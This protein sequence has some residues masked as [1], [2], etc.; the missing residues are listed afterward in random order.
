MTG[1]PG[2][3]TIVATQESPTSLDFHF[4][5]SDISARQVVETG[6]FVQVDLGQDLVLG[7]I[8]SLRRS[9]RYF[10]SPDII[11]GSSQGNS[12]PSVYPSDRWDYLVAHVKVLGCFRDGLQI[13]STRPVLPGS[14]VHMVNETILRQFLGLKKQGL[15]LGKLRQSN[16]PAN[17]DLDR[18][19]KKHLAILSISGGGKSYATSV[20]I[21]ELLRRYPDQ[22]RPAMVM[23]DVHGEYSSLTQ[24][25]NDR[26]F[27]DVE[28]VHVPSD[29][30]AMSVRNLE[31]SDFA[32]FFPS[33]SYAQ[34]RELQAVLSQL[35]K[36]GNGL[37]IDHIISAIYEREMNQLVKDALLGWVS[38]LKHS[39]LFGNAEFPHIKKTLEPGKLIIL[40][41]SGYTSL[42]K[43]R[44]LVHYFLTRIFDLRRS[45]DI[46]PVIS[47]IEEAHQFAPEVESSTSK[48]IIH[49]I[50]REGRKFLCSLVLISQRPVNLSTTALSQCNSQLILRIL[51]P[52]DLNYIGK[53]SE[54]IN[55]ETLSMLTS[56]GVG[57]AL[58]VG[59]AIN[60]PVFMQIRKKL[61]NADYDELSLSAE[62][63][64]YDMLEIK[65]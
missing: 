48:S 56:L 47:F 61:I 12:V 19:L 24:L 27:V 2:L 18:L 25:Q 36:K 4:V 53:T 44:I 10:S 31:T 17:I 33:M 62:S 23:F 9:N 8:Q 45:R 3:G 51:N 50:A 46:P 37:T 15:Q 55:S 32:R 35:R 29:S 52:H 28:V 13:R 42:W 38:Q 57:E 64:K 39:Y 40:D 14:V 34:Q 54:G 16:T 59:A 22:G 65:R 21:E 30:I 26:N 43:K 6:T 41:L 58:L 20:I 11:H 1:I 7:V 60:Y 63:K 49:T 5:I